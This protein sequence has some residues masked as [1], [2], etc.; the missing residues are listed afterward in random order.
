MSNYQNRNNKEYNDDGNM[1]FNEKPKQIHIDPDFRM[2]LK[3]KIMN[4]YDK[5]VQSTTSAVSSKFSLSFIAAVATSFV[6]VVFIASTM[7]VNPFGG[8]I[9]TDKTA[10]P[11]DNASVIKKLVDK[12]PVL[13]QSKVLAAQGAANAESAATNTRSMIL[14]GFGGANG[15]FTAEMPRFMYSKEIVER[16]PASLK[17]D[18]Y[19]WY[20]T[21]ISTTTDMYTYVDPDSNEFRSVQIIKAKDGTLLEYTS[22]DPNGSLEYYGGKYAVRINF[23]D[24]PDVPEKSVVLPSEDL[25]TSDVDVMPTG[26]AD[27]QTGE[28]DNPLSLFGLDNADVKTVDK[29]GRKYYV[30][31]IDNAY[32]CSDSFLLGKDASA[33]TSEEHS[34]EQMWFDANSYEL[35]KSEIYVGTVAKENLVSTIT[36]ESRASD[37]DYADVAQYFKF[38]Y[39]V[40]IKELNVS[41]FYMDDTT[42]IEA[43][44]KYLKQNPT[45]IILPTSNSGYT[46]SWIGT[47]ELYGEDTMA[48][49]YS[50]YLDRDFYADNQYGEAA[51]RSMSQMVSSWEGESRVDPD[52]S[53]SFVS[54][55]SMYSF[56]EA[57]YPGSVS[58]EDLLKSIAIDLTIDDKESKNLATTLLID[59]K[60]IDVAAYKGTFGVVAQCVNCPDM[61]EDDSLYSQYI[62]I[63]RI[64]GKAYVL[65]G[66][67]K[68]IEQLSFTTID[69]ANTKQLNTLMNDYKKNLDNL[70]MLDLDDLAQ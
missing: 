21:N 50:H 64:G 49:Q 70:D 41:D 67:S 59:G 23:P 54:N 30:V 32:P 48:K 29:D 51:Y 62:Y 40:E 22:S 2:E 45:K 63:L 33:K 4:E 10:E 20:D 12:N 13:F 34:I 9:K 14:P 57:I 46:L 43:I 31:T 44:E 37:D 26:S 5:Q 18:I 28:N 68:N 7:F 38:P 47:K 42:E 8:G 53:L 65:Q 17:C 25:G 1:L 35:V 61:E 15:P 55:D 36:F 16:G 69:T 56:D 58:D 6:L 3:E 19:G 60:K 27:E 39:D 66:G 52:V 11:V 24:M